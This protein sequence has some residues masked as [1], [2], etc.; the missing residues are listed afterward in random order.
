M[1]ERRQRKRRV[2]KMERVSGSY[3]KTLEG[4][5]EPMGRER[6]ER[7]VRNRTSGEREQ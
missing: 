1:K 3:D 6:E 7:I 4:M 2:S 5:R